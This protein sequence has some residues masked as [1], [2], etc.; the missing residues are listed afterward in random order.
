MIDSLSGKKKKTPF[1][2]PFLNCKGH[3]ELMYDTCVSVALPPPR[4]PLYFSL[5]LPGLI[6]G[7]QSQPTALPRSLAPIGAFWESIR[8]S[9]Q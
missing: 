2:T 5:S 8:Y 7:C 6:T 1:P 3:A 9:Q 4:T